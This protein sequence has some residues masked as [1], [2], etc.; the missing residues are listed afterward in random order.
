MSKRDG[1]S[2][3]GSMF[4][5]WGI[6]TLLLW[7][8]RD[9]SSFEDTS[10]TQQPT[11][12][13]N[14]DN[15]NMIG[16]CIPVVLGR[17]MVKSPLISFYDDF[18]ALPYTEE[19]GMHSWIDW[20]AILWPFIIQ[21]LL[22]VVQPNLVIGA[23]PGTEVTQQQKNAYMMNLL[24]Q[25]LILI[26]MSLFSDHAG[27]V[28]IQKGFK[29]YLGWQHIICW[30]GENIGIRKIWMN[31]YDAEV[32]ASTQKGVWGD[33]D[34]IAYKKDNPTG[35]V[36][37]IDDPMM[38]GGWDEGGGF[39]GDIRVY[40]GTEEQGKDSWMVK[41]MTESTNIPDELKGLTPV[42]PMF[43][44]SVIP[45]AY[46]GKQATIPEMWFEVVNFP[47]R[48]YQDYKY[49]MQG[50]Y[51]EYMSNYLD[52][53]YGY[54]DKQ[55]PAVKVYIK[56]YKDALDD[57]KLAYE[58]VARDANYWLKEM[59]NA[60]SDLER[61]EISGDSTKIA[62]LQKV[63]DDAVTKFDSANSEAQAKYADV[64][65]ALE[66]LL[67]NYPP[68]KRDEFATY[69]DKIINLLDNGV[70]HLGRLD[71]DLN[72]AEAI[73][74]ILTNPD[75][76]C[77]YTRIFEIDTYSL[78]RLGI[79]CEEEHMGI[80]CLINNISTANDYINKI[81]DHIGGVKY[82]NPFTGKLTFKLLRRDYVVDNL[83]EFNTSNCSTCEFS[84]LDWSEVV[85]NV[86]IS[87]TYAADKYMD[88]QAWYYDLASRL[89]TSSYSDKNIDGR[90]FTTPAN[91]RRMAQTKLLT[92]G[93]PLASVELKCN[94]IGQFITVGDPIL[95]NWE[96]YGIS[97]QVFR[98]TNIDYATLT[99]N[100]ITVS[101]IEDVF[102]FEDTNYDYSDAPIW[103]EP[104]K[105]LEDISAY[106]I[107]ELPY[108][109]T[110]STTT[111]VAVCAAKPNADCVYYNVWRYDKGTYGKSA[112]TNSWGLVAQ[113]V[114]GTDEEYGYSSTDIEISLIGN[115]TRTLFEDKIDKMARNPSV[116]TQFSG[117]N[118]LMMDDEILSYE[119]MEV[120]ANGNVV[121]RNVVRGVY[122]TLP[123]KH[124]AYTKVFL[125]DN[126]LD[127]NNNMPV[128]SA[129]DYAD[130][131]IE[132][133]TSAASTEQQFDI[134]KINHFYTKRRSE[135][136]TPM[137]NLQF[138]A[139]RGT[140]TEY[141]YNKPAGTT[142]SGDIKTK[143]YIRNKFN[144]GGGIYLQTN[145]DDLG[146][147]EDNLKYY[148]KYAS[149][150]VDFEKR[151]DSVK[152]GVDPTT[153][154]PYTEYPKEFDMT[155][156][157]FC[158]E[159][160]NRLMERNEVTLEIGTY[161]ADKGLH[162]YDHYEKHIFYATPRVAGI[163][164]DS[165]T[166]LDDVQAYAD[167]IVQPTIVE[168]P[169]SKYIQDTTMTYDDCPLIMVAT[170]VN[171]SSEII[172]QN[173]TG[174]DLGTKAYR[175]DGYDSTTNKAIIHEITIDPE[176]V[177]RTNFNS[178]EKDKKTFWKYRSGSWISFSVYTTV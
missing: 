75:W 102:G 116:Y 84:R 109:L 12:Y 49:E 89:I 176:Y 93:Y 30:T 53:V 169:A 170:G 73:Y 57:A 173:G 129:G 21:A 111:R 5:G 3:I 11:K 95:V 28:T 33:D 35:I 61:A 25:L 65:S 152:H 68:S 1:S 22:V 177:F 29:Y 13:S 132:L 83:Y 43:M 125:L 149:N 117:K 54:L 124:T 144:N 66:D 167:S 76:G 127:I 24:F 161:N 108:E 139:D 115:D 96:P 36:A 99:S 70:W 71:D 15:C 113:L 17:A 60:R 94:R 48:L 69:A 114:Y 55:D 143:F 138:G 86:S 26:L 8:F 157:Y 34:H 79:T 37:H 39:I 159:M 40:F 136:P 74:E 85:S 19:Y 87:F 82:D 42:Y 91:A 14:A 67:N 23:F 147:M 119:K 126:T 156:A 20:N 160:G 153:S 142:Y 46:I 130:E 47:N 146:V 131:Q 32:E 77:D 80:S 135:S 172:M 158:S 106:L 64:R 7:L 90:Y 63:Y 110:S 162:S 52:E 81:L 10:T 78:L 56:D 9:K 59:D 155:W 145:S 140:E 100:T 148:V 134:D 112:I 62:E 107:Y 175:I 88:A 105:I 72:P 164:M 18:E 58:I 50:I 120:L 27:R 150:D 163:I 97:K 4:L 2:D 122:D 174:V 6:S 44:T 92:Y 137:A 123:K 171:T 141:R 38:F 41:N 168:I 133:T 128:A 178:S 118:L 101:A 166:L 121:L 154:M 165:P 104:E 103:T 51:L 31:V 151:Y 98:V 45:K 16:S